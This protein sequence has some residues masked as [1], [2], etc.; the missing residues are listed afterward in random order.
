LIGR[1]INGKK[2][3][4]IDKLKD[5]AKRLNVHLAIL[6]VPDDAAQDVADILSECDI[7]AIWNFTSVHLK[8]SKDILVKEENLASSLSELSNYLSEKV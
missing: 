2:V 5:I 7:L 4:S 8:V 3:F 1:E 6:T